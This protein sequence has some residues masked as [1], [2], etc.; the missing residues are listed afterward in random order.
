MDYVDALVKLSRVTAEQWGLV[1]TEQAEQA[2]VGAACFGGLVQSGVLVEAGAYV[3]QLAGAPLPPHLDIKVAWLRLEPGKPAWRR[4]AGNSGVISHSSACLLHGLGDLPVGT[5]EMSAGARGT[6]EAGVR[7][8]NEPRPDPAQITVVDG[9]PVTT[10][11]RT[12]TDL[13]HTG[14]DGGHVGGVVADAARLGLVDLRSLAQQVAVFASAYGLPASASG[15]DLIS[16]LL[17]DAGEQTA[18]SAVA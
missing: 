6:V 9:L 7:V 14:L 10:V 3:F 17:A 1:T 5:V 4:K 12:I 8:H 16:R 15:H 11:G 2:G 13:L 18:A